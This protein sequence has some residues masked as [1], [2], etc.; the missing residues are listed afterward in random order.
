MPHSSL[1]WPSIHRLEAV[2]IWR[3]SLCVHCFSVRGVTPPW[4]ADTHTIC[5]WCEL[6]WKL[7]E[8]AGSMTPRTLMEAKH[9]RSITSHGHPAP[10]RG[11]VSLPCVA[12]HRTCPS[13]LSYF[14]YWCPPSP[15]LLL[16]LFCFRF[17]VCSV[18]R[19]C[20]SC[21]AWVLHTIR[22]QWSPFTSVILWS[23]AFY[24]LIIVE[25]ALN[26]DAL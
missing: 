2:R 24:W 9:E 15:R 13:L 22:G 8:Q 20:R 10:L 19:M 7:R 5:I 16:L 18:L 25:M 23:N 14:S 4:F 1:I 12:L 17:C 3:Q 26:G 11:C 6:S 21:A